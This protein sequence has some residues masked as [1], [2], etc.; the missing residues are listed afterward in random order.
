MVT[1]ENWSWLRRPP[2]EPGRCQFQGYT[3]YGYTQGSCPSQCRGNAEAKELYNP[4]FIGTLEKPP[5]F[6]LACYTN[7]YAGTRSNF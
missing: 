5:R 7:P 3:Q 2:S 1:F 6:S 4:L